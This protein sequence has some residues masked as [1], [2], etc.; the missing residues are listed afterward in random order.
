MDFESTVST[1]FTTP[2][3]ERI[4]QEPGLC[5]NVQSRSLDSNK[6]MLMEY[7][8]EFAID[9]KIYSVIQRDKI[10]GKRILPETD[11]LCVDISRLSMTFWVL[12]CI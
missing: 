7:C 8:L 1:N 10:R 4:L 5:L 2:A 9:S 12:F 3:A 6:V 11:Q